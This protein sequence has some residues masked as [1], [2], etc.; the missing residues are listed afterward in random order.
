MRSLSAPGSCPHSTETSDQDLTVPIL[1]K[2]RKKKKGG[3]EEKEG[4][5]KFTIFCPEM[6]SKPVLVTC[7]MT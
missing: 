3:K 6:D 7:V 4:C 1:K 5:P 2:K